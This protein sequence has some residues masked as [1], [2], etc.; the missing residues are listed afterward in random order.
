MH[1]EPY[2]YFDGRCEEAVDFYRRALGAELVTLV[3]F[4]DN[5]GTPAPAG[6]GEKV[7]HANLRFG[8]TTVL[9][10]DGQRSGTPSFQ[11]F[12]LAL[13]AADSS[14]AERLFAALAEGGQVQMP[15]MSTAFSPRFG[16]IIDRFGVLWTISAE[17]VQQAG[18]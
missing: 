11:G 7:M 15:L 17:A 5:P 4:K 8:S 10:S 18:A 6:A 1:V 9:A 13:T 14:E 2:L 12:S 3:R 16:M